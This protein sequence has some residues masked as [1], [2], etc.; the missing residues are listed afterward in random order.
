M[1]K[2]L[3]GT[4]ALAILVGSLTVQAAENTGSYSRDYGQ[5]MATSAQASAKN[6]SD[7]SNKNVNK[8]GTPGA[9]EGASPVKYNAN[10]DISY[11]AD[12][13]NVLG[14]AFSKY[15]ILENN[16][17]VQAIGT[18]YS[19]DVQ[20]ALAELKTKLLTDNSAQDSTKDLKNKLD[21]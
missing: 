9:E 19:P 18:S 8:G 12:G 20:N 3:I 6:I 7:E 17:E 2:I 14:G 15:M 1:K 10:D 11:D 21:E 4:S 16:S 5:A 13:S